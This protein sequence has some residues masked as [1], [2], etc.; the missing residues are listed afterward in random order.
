MGSFYT[1]VIRV[2]GG[3]LLAGALALGLGSGCVTLD[4]QF[5]QKS[6]AEGARL[7][8]AG[9]YDGAAGAYTNATKKEPRDYKAYYY[10]GCS[11]DATKAWEKA[12]HAYKTSLDVMALTFQGQHDQDFRLKVLDGL[13]QSIARSDTRQVE[14]DLAERQSRTKHEAEPYFLVAKIYRYSGDA[15]LAVENYNKANLMD[16][17]NVAYVRELGLYFEQIGQQQKAEP[18]LRRAYS[19]GAH[20]EQVTAAMRRIGVIPGPAI[21]PQAQLVQPVVPQGPIPEVKLSGASTTSN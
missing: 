21:K 8:N 1:R 4:Q 11:Y 16:P 5:S 14:L 19:L 12:I 7:Y 2:Q 6:H 9:D 20:D 18:A 15:D 10:L 17:E 3:M 13:S